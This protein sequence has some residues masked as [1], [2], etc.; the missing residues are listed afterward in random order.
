MDDPDHLFQELC[1][2]AAVACGDDIAAIGRYISRRIETM[3]EAEQ[4]AITRDIRRV[5]AFMP[6]NRPLQEH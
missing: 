4:S 3:N 6:P 2:E 5:L 1:L